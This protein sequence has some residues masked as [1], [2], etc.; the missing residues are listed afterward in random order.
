MTAPSVGMPY[1]SSNIPSVAMAS[2][3]GPTVTA[4]RGRS[5]RAA[6]EIAAS[7][8]RW[9][10]DG[11]SRTYLSLN[12]SW[13][14]IGVPLRR[15]DKWGPRAPMTPVGARGPHLSLLR[16]GTPISIHDLF[17]DKYVLLAASG[18]QRWRD[19]AISVAA[20]SDLPLSAVTVGPNGD[21]IAT[22]GMFED[23]YGI[24]TDGAVIVRPDGVVAWRVTS[25]DQ[26]AEE[27]IEA[28]M[29]RLLGRG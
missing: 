5:L 14:E 6:T 16:N 18:G 1:E 22:E 19:A 8:Q 23:S 12:R 10:P 3:F 29:S 21:A 7:R 4:E 13:I 24:P 17:R 11:A 20:R 15:R 9:P 27:A 26:D 28:A 25:S 2:P